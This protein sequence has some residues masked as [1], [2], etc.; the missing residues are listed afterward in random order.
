[1]VLR[2]TV[3]LT[4]TVMFGDVLGVVVALLAQWLDSHFVLGHRI[5]LS[6]GVMPHVRMVDHRQA[7]SVACHENATAHFSAPP[8]LSLFVQC[9]P[10][11]VRL[12]ITFPCS[13]VRITII[14]I[15]TLTI[16]VTCSCT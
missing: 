3:W 6:T 10:G 5:K 4:C 16:I 11:R 14:Q 2:N 8:R 7:R 15:V 1:M 9:L 13:S 12:F